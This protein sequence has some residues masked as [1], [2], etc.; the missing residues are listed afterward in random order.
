MRA[1]GGGA[2]SVAEQEARLKPAQGVEEVV[3]GWGPPTEAGGRH[4]PASAGQASR[5]GRG[6]PQALDRSE[7]PADQAAPAAGS[8]LGPALAGRCLPPA[9][10]GGIEAGPTPKCLPP[11]LA[12]GIK[13]RHPAAARLC[14]TASPRP[15]A[16]S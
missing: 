4:R 5:A 8:L 3:W 10:A 11:A 6:K 7:T 16:A 9:L 12:G 2:K 14:W 1:A 13:H 15:A